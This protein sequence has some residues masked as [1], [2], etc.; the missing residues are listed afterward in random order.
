MPHIPIPTGLA[1]FAL[2]QAIEARGD[3]LDRL[4]TALDDELGKTT[5]LSAAGLAPLRAIPMF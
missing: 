2:K 3:E 1:G 4:F 5:G